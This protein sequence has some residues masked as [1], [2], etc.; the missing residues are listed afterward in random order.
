[1][2]SV[3]V[4]HGRRTRQRMPNEKRWKRQQSTPGRDWRFKSKPS[5]MHRIFAKPFSRNTAYVM[6]GLYRYLGFLFYINGWRLRLQ[7]LHHRLPRD[8][9]P[10]ITY[11]AVRKCFSSSYLTYPFYTSNDRMQDHFRYFANPEISHE[12]NNHDIEPSD[13]PSTEVVR[14]SMIINSMK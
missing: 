1:M 14:H 5:H 8:R 6:F 13:L 11:L 3:Y 12:T 10:A 7:Q 4:A 9:A 2:G